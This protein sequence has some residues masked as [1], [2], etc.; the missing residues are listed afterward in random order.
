MCGVKYM[1]D[2]EFDSKV[3]E[4]EKQIKVIEAYDK[5]YGQ[6]KEVRDIIDKKK[7]LIHKALAE[8]NK[9]LFGIKKEEK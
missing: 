6:V 5:I 1:S 9:W 2:E 7:V 4:I 8:K 3:N